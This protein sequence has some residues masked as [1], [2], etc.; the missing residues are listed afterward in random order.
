MKA[1]VFLSCGQSK[2]SDEPRIAEKIQDR[3]RNLGFDCYM[4]VAEQSLRGLRE[5]IFAQLESSDYLVFVD[6]KR[7]E[8]SIPNSKPA[9][10][11]SLFSHQELAIASYLEIPALVFQENGVKPLD[12]MLGAMQANAVPFTDKNLLPNA[13]AD[14]V[15][16]RSRNGEWPTDSKSILTLDVTDPPYT[17]ALQTQMGMRRFYHIAV[18]NHH[19]RKAALY[20]SAHLDTILNE[21][22]KQLTRPK[23]V[24]FKW[25]GTTISAV[26]I[27][28][29]TVREF[30][31]VDF[32]LWPTID[33]QFAPLT[34]SPHYRPK[35]EGPGKYVLSF[36]V[37]SQNFE[38]TT[39]DFVLEY[40]KG[41]ESVTFSI[42]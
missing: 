14:F 38:T 21:K 20:C 37:A 36:S 1:K 18:R 31:A 11:G 33:P 22:T 40:A 25:S 9:W 17:D 4:A 3:I 13:I 16:E 19:H 26:R 32:F 35:L 30:D 23:T 28:P 6:F 10:R 29:K 42:A 2:G 12:G 24:E 27:A 39:R 34:D 5:N 8:L 15:G 41:A 7:E